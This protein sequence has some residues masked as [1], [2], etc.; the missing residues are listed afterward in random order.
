MMCG[1]THRSIT[2]QMFKELATLKMKTPID[3]WQRD[4][5][6]DGNREASWGCTA[7]D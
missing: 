7:G 5:K 6:F 2:K 3:L 1:Q 4:S